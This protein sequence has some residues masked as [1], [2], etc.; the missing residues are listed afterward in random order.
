MLGRCTSRAT[1]LA[2]SEYLYSLL[3]L[4]CP[5]ET[6]A[7]TRDWHTHWPGLMYLSLLSSFT[8]EIMLICCFLPYDLYMLEHESM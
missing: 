6:A 3:I 2:R 8:F 1:L 7:S 4:L 5:T